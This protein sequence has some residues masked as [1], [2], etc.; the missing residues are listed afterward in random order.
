MQKKKEVDVTTY[1]LKMAWSCCNNVLLKVT[2]EWFLQSEHTSSPGQS[3]RPGTAHGHQTASGSGWC[4]S[5]QPP[6]SGSPCTCQSN[7][8]KIVYSC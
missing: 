6:S 8:L 1:E 7:E 3:G 4:C 5:G 2:C